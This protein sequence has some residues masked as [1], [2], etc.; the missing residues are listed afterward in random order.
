MPQYPGSVRKVLLPSATT[1]IFCCCLFFFIIFGITNLYAQQQDFK[2]SSWTFT[3]RMLANS[4]AEKTDPEEFEVYSSLNFGVA[5]KRA[6]WNNF[7]AELS[8]STESREVDYMESAIK[9][10]SLG[11]LELLPVNL[12]IQYNAP[13]KGKFHPYI[14]VGANF[15]KCWEKSGTLNSNKVTKSFGPALQL[16]F[17]LDIAPHLLFNFDVKS[18][19]M[20]TDVNVDEGRLVK[21]DMNPLS[22]SVG[23]GVRL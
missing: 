7:A 17:D 18:V 19:A 12:V 16:G 13:L 11:A 8:L 4:K 23:L 21:I 3:T 15:T 2:T 22:V 14:G 5:V 10:V 9:E 1:V 6:I 20:S